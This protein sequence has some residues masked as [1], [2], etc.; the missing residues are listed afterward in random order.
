MGTFYLLLDGAQAEG[1][2]IH[3]Q[4]L[5][6]SNCSL[7]E[8]KKMRHLI[9]VSPFLFTFEENTEFA[10]WYFQNGWG[11]SWGILL[12]SSASF[13]FLLNHFRRFLIM[14][15]EQGKDL[16]F[17]F[18]DPRVLRGFLPGYDKN[19]LIEFFGPVD[20]FYCEDESPET[21]L[22]FSQSKGRLNTAKE[23]SKKFFN[24]LGVKTDTQEIKKPVEDKVLENQ[25][26]IVNP[27]TD[28]PA[29]KSNSGRWGW[30][31]NN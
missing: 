8:G 15:G 17:R 16:Y 31:D 20:T 1:S 23:S 21:V 2:I 24:E 14:P 6:P 19:Q 29:K 25:A 26:K 7:Y 28:K 22:L 13:D 5:N 10:N 30:V 27:V 3:A 9:S 4:K 18:Y 12:S 11:K